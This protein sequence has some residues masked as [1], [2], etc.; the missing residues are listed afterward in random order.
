[1]FPNVEYIK[2]LV[3]G[4]KEFVSNSIKSVRKD[5]ESKV[6]A[7]NATIDGLPQADW[8]QNDSAAKDYVKNRTHWTESKEVSSGFGRVG[9]AN[10]C[11]LGARK[12]S[13]I[14]ADG[15]TYTDVPVDMFTNGRYLQSEFGGYTFCFDQ[16]YGT[17][18]VTPSE[19]NI[20]GV[21]FFYIA[22]TVHKLPD[23]YVPDWVARSDD[24]P[25]VP[26]QVNADW[27][28]TNE[29]SKAYIRNKPYLDDSLV[30]CDHL[31]DSQK[32]Y[33]LLSLAPHI[34][35]NDGGG[36][37]VIKKMPLLKAK[38]ANTEFDIVSVLTGKA[39]TEAECPYG[40]IML[41]MAAN[42]VFCL[43]PN[44]EEEPI[45]QST[46]PSSTKKF[47]ITV[48]DSGTLSAVEVTE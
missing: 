26:D 39:L 25:D 16:V 32:S 2:T 31:Y 3:N 21:Q 30:Y 11:R 10:G 43:N 34:Y 1:M 19:S 17:V 22:D 4:L 15:E 27:D 48:D 24:I 23:K 36:A 14:L 40:A 13:K 33:R 44:Y 18:E 5:T 9:F 20:N 45:L 47:K 35:Y 41:M 37:L 46:T 6:D 8:N 7:I 38:Y 28:E 29:S 12:F 42:H